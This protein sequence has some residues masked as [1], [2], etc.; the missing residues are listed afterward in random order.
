MRSVDK[1]NGEVY[2]TAQMTDYVTEQQ[3]DRIQDWINQLMDGKVAKAVASS[4]AQMYRGDD[5]RWVRQN[6]FVIHMHATPRSRQTLTLELLDY[7]GLDY[8]QYSQVAAAAELALIKYV[9]AHD[10]IDWAKRNVDR[11]NGDSRTFMVTTV[12]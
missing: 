1:L 7:L 12:A 6:Y 4:E 3:A 8:H 10:N 11:C 9:N 5:G 2:P